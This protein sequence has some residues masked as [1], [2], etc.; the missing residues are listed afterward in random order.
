[1]AVRERRV[2]QEYCLMRK[3]KTRFK[4]SSPMMKGV[5]RFLAFRKYCTY[6]QFM[7]NFSTILRD[8]VFLSSSDAMT[9]RT[10]AHEV[11]CHF[12]QYLNYRAGFWLE[13]ASSKAKRAAYEAEA[14]SAGMTMDRLLGRRTQTVDAVMR[15]LGGYNLGESDLL[16][17]RRIL[18]NIWTMR[19][20][21]LVCCFPFTDDILEICKKQG[22]V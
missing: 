12:G 11:G 20:S 21:H 5:G 14:Y 4:R 22:V 19:T 9:P 16:N 3:A 6:D 18:E 17:T 7:N 13:Y 8:T 2:W 10:L 15:K 1:M